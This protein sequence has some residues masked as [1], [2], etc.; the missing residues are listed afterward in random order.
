MTPIRVWAP[1]AQVVRCVVGAD[2]HPMTAE[3]DGWWSWTPDGE[4]WSELDYLVTVDGSDPLPDPRSA[5]LPYGVHGPSRTFDA[6]DFAWSDDRWRGPCDGRGTLGGVY[7]ELHVGTFTQA[8]TLTGA[9]AHLDDLVDLGVDVVEVMPVAAFGGNHGWGYDGVQPFAVH[10]PYGGPR[11]LQE[12]VDA[13]HARGLGV[14]L[15][16]VYNHVGPV[17]NYLSTFGPYF[18]E[19]HSTPWGP[20]LNLDGPGSGEVRRWVLD[21]ALRWFRDF[22]VDALRLDAVH[23]FHDDSPLHLLAELS[24]ATAALS[25]E[26]G[27]PLDLVAESDLNDP[28]M[29]LPTAAGGRGMTAQWDDDVHHALH[30]ALT[31]ERR[32][33]YADF[34]GG[35]QAWPDGTPL[36]VLAKTLTEVFLHDGRFSTFRGQVWGAPVD[37]HRVSGHRFLAYLQNHDQVG[38]R[39]T[40]DR[41]SET[42]SPGQ[43][44]IGAALYLLSPYTPMVFMGEE[45]RASTPFQYFTS[46]E[47]RW[48]GDAVRKGRREEF[49]A[50]G[51]SADDIPD[52][53][54]PATRSASI[55]AWAERGGRGHT[56]MLDFY[57]ELIKVRR[58]EPDARSGD[59][60]ATQVEVDDENGWLIMHRRSIH[61]VCNFRPRSQVVPLR[62]LQVERVLASWAR[63]PVVDAHGIRLD[64]HDVAV[65]RTR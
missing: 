4:E 30:V 3:D 38:N 47:D 25:A 8:G 36:R 56:A 22:H 45:W 35:T 39:A 61:V 13:C 19:R 21:N 65:L 24:D 51:W 49:A 7:Y 6:G 44:A 33:Y 2:H 62:G 9:I 28:V 12:F 50:H 29:V 17:G 43:Q 11:A 10:H 60:G 32:G 59:L 34:A 26:L 63:A 1:E 58:R 14:C 27:R 16:V 20:A 18:T 46:F 37:P 15:D 52:P 42:I 5:C 54:D 23:A 40:G 53:Q 48:L 64:G 31:G 57:R 41:I 55:L